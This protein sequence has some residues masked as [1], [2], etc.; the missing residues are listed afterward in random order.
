M[1]AKKTVKKAAPKKDAPKKAA[2]KKA[3]PKKAAPKAD[4]TATP[5][6]AAPKKKAAVKLTD[7]QKGLLLAVMS[8][9]DEGHLAAKGE[10]ATLKSLAT[11]KFL[12]SG[13]KNAVT[14]KAPYIITV[15]GKKHLA[16]APAS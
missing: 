1:A 12:K 4:A 14:K 5:K 7:K 8:K 15:A 13:K 9:G 6:K 11:K 2:P 10:E 16:E 3:A